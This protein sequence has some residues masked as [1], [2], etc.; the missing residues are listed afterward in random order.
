M[1]IQKR[2]KNHQR[3]WNISLTQEDE[4]FQFR[5]RLVS[6]LDTL[7]CRHLLEN[8][9]F[10]QKF[11][12]FYN[13]VDP[14]IPGFIAIMPMSQSLDSSALFRRTYI[15]EKISECRSTRQIANF[16][17]ILFW[18]LE[19]ESFEPN[20]LSL[21][22]QR[23]IKR[24]SI[25]T[26]NASFQIKQKGKQFIVYP[27]GDQLLDE[28]IINYTLSGLEDYP[29]VAKSFENAL[30]IYQ[31][32][33]VGKYR[34]LLDNL[35]L[36]LEQ[37]LKKILRNGKSLENQNKIL[38]D[39]L[40]EKRLHSQ[41]VHL[42]GHLL[43][44]YQQYQNDAVKH[45]DNNEAMYSIDDVEFMIYLTGNFMRLILKLAIEDA[46]MNKSDGNC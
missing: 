24:I 7:Y 3:R 37:L 32:G 8:K 6:V 46:S 19:E 40:K 22:I 43:R 28:E 36:A 27:S 13:Y 21:R 14:L 10:D 9:Y 34:D 39:W 4:F 44:S 41:V 18:A 15:Y 1:Q 17:Q 35:R 29:E 25:L 42:Y 30:M 45:N 38:N 16:V 33:E 20:D 31:S 5:Y 12:Q 2:L 26:P 11:R 23:E